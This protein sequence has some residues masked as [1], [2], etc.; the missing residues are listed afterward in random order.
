MRSRR[1]SL[2]KAGDPPFEALERFV[3]LR[4][5]GGEALHFPA[6]DQQP[7][8]L[9]HVV[10]DA[11]PQPPRR[12]GLPRDESAPGARETVSG[13]V[14]DYLGQRLLGVPAQVGTQLPQCGCEWVLAFYVNGAGPQVDVHVRVQL[15]PRF[16]PSARQD[17]ESQDRKRGTAHRKGLTCEGGEA[18]A[19]SRLRVE[20]AIEQE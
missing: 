5:L 20:Q 10:R 8:L 12:I 19:R 7:L 13:N 14:A 16:E 18:L 1:A 4:D 17:R 6:T 9:H 2:A 15:G 11:F 3:Q